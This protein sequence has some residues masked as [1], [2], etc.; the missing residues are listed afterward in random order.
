VQG[1]CRSAG[2]GCLDCKQP[3]IDAIN[4]EL[5]PIQF[6]IKEYESDFEMV[7]AVINEGTEAARELARATLHEV[8]QAMGL[9][10]R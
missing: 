7:Q 9:S 3:L 10:Y 1:G 6:R 8:R 4:A 5:D 2:I